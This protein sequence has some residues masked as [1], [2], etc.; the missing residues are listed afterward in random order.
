MEGLKE[1]IQREA[2]DLSLFSSLLPSLPSN[3]SVQA[4]K[5]KSKSKSKSNS[6]EIPPLVLVYFFSLFLLFIWN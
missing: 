2:G 3:P 4:I 1:R 6:A 5:S